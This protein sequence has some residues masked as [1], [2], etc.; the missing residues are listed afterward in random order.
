ML[1]MY[2]ALIAGFIVHTL[3][4]WGACHQTHTQN[5]F[6]QFTFCV[7]AT[8]E[9][10]LLQMMLIYKHTGAPRPP[11]VLCCVC[12]LDSFQVHSLIAACV[13]LAG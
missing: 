6:I 13:R 3:R 8:P 12:G 10:D 9:V 2:R 1:I 4:S 11:P 7:Y 5:A